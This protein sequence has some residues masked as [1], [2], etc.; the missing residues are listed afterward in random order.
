M[1]YGGGTHVFYS[2]QSLDTVSRDVGVWTGRL[3]LSWP[4]HRPREML[5]LP[6]LAEFAFRL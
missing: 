6:V 4:W 1:Q 3:S 2:G 5:R